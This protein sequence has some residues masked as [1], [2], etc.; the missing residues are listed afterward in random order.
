ML[1]HSKIIYWDASVFLSYINEEKTTSMTTLEALLNLSSG[2]NSSTKLYTS[3]LSHVEVAFA[4]SERR[5]Q[6]LDPYQE[7][8]ISDLWTGSNAVVSVDVHQ[9]VSRLATNLMRDSITHGWSLKPADAVHL[10]TAQWLSNTDVLVA[11]FHTYDRS[12]RKYE[13]LVGFEITEPYTEQ[14]TLI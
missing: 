13:A 8:R 7:R 10:A 9:G 4:D 5:R 14:P 3:T 11:E 6:T 2:T 12:L 1:G